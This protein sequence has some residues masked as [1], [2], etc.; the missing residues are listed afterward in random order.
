MGVKRVEQIIVARQE[1]LHNLVHSQAPDPFTRM[2][3][4]LLRRARIA[5]LK[6]LSFRETRDG[7]S[8]FSPNHPDLIAQQQYREGDVGLGK[9]PA[10]LPV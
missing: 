5:S 2:M 4:V 10:Q 1:S 3:S 9:E 7:R 8:S 6:V